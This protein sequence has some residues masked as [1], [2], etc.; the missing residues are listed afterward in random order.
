MNIYVDIDNIVADFEGAFRRNLN[1]K[2]NRSLKQA[3]I[4][5]FDFFRCYGISKEEEGAIHQEFIKRGGYRKLKKI[6]G[7]KQGIKE[8]KRIGDVFLITARPEALRKITTDWLNHK[9]IDI[10]E[11]HVIFSKNK[12]DDRHAIDIIVEDKWEDAIDLAEKGYEVILYDY[13]WNRK[14]GLSGNIINNSKIGRVYSWKDIIANV[15]VAAEKKRE[16]VEKDSAVLKIWKES[17]RVQMHFNEMIMR[18]RIT[19]ASIIFAAFGAVLTLQKLAQPSESGG[20]AVNGGVQLST[21]ILIITAIA[22]LSYGLVDIGYY[23][24]LLVGAVKF[25]EQIDKKYRGL[26]LTSSITKEIKHSVAMWM[27][28]GYYLIIILGLVMT[29]LIKSRI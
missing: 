16:I 4:S 12:A 19:F 21:V 18:N 9:G 23:Y 3:D 17:I 1:K 6:K 24:R 8:L 10:R 5:E 11:D 14:R 22:I 20:A 28:I 7:S 2:K 15:G 13:P 27:L 25:T 26:G 29:A